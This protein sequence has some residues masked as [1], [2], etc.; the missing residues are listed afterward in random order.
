MSVNVVCFKWGRGAFGP[1]YVNRLASMV[2]RHLSLPH[3]FVCFTDDEAGID[4]T[5]E[6]QPLPEW[7]VP[8]PSRSLAPW[9]KLSAL[10]P[11][12]G[13]L[14]GKT[15]YLDLDVVI[16]DNID[17]LFA[18]SPKLATS[19]NWTQR[20]QGIGN[21][22][23]YA[24]EIGQF[25]HVVEAYER[26]F[27]RLGIDY[28]NSQTFMCRK[29]GR[30]NIEWWPDDWVVS[31]KHTCMPKGL[32]QWIETPRLPKNTRIVVFHGNPKPEHAIE[33]VW[34]RKWYKHVRPTPWVAEHWR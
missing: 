32:M 1:E 25:A 15:L 11:D 21:T 23:V 17:P 27:E 24:Y 6:T 7:R 31:F 5:I 9:R 4:P 8:P 14:S 28:V 20:G 19:E 12:L 22:S 33:G 2:R 34:P 13:G 30:E 16:T 26:E 18:F 3:R 10:L 29:I